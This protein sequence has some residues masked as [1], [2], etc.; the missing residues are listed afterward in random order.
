MTSE[1][2]TASQLLT[3]SIRVAECLK[4]YGI[5]RGDSIAICCENRVEVTYVMFG[6]F[7]VGA[8]YIPLNPTYTE[9]TWKLQTIKP[10][11]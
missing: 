6:I 9:G 11:A 7:F 4:Y 3:Q 1:E 10:S 8:K 2:V 5:K